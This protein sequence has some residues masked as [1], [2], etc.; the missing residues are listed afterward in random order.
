MTNVTHTRKYFEKL[1]EKGAA[2]DV[3][4]NGVWMDGELIPWAVAFPSWNIPRGHSDEPEA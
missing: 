4:I 3:E 2:W 1:A